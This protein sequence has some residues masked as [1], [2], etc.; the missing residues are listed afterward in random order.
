MTEE[1]FEK[2]LQGTA[3]DYNVPPEIPRDEMWTNIQEGR[4]RRRT[5]RVVPLPSPQVRWGLGVA[6]ALVIGIGIGMFVRGGQPANP[7][8]A[9]GEGTDSIREA[10]QDIYR[11]V[12]LEH[13]GRAE[14]FLTMFRS[15]VRAGQTDYE[16]ANPARELLRA[17]RLLQTSPASR[18]EPLRELLGEL[19]LLLAQIAHLRTEL[20]DEDA[21][22]IADGIEQGDVLLKLREAVPAARTLPGV[23][24]VL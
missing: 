24:G 7:L 9:T 21:Q 13:L 6:A 20:G 12:A 1:Q 22:L 17:N 10:D 4:R 11:L 18:D 15:D 14:V 23:Q 3:K 16:I 5:I 19:E 2:F 8:V